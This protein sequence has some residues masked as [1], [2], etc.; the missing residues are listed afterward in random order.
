[1]QIPFFYG[2]YFPVF[3]L[4]TEIYGVNFK[5][6]L[7]MGIYGPKN[8]VFGQFS[9]SEQL[10]HLASGKPLRNVYKVVLL[11]IPMMREY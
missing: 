9:R 7:N 1:M 5:F 3:G 2:P 4:N 6:N 8:S 10:N 11:V